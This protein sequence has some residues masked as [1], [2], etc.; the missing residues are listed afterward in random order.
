NLR[1]PIALRVNPDVDPRTHEYISTGSRENKLGIALDHIDAVYDRAARMRNI[2]IVGGQ[3][4]IGSQITEAKPFAN[5][6]KKVAPLVRELKSKY[7]IKFFSIG[8]G[9]GII[10]RHALESGSGKWWHDH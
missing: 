8:G 2:D 3:M 1:A 10:Y 6:I 9:M 5:A 7:A 4:H